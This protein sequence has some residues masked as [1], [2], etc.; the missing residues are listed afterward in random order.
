M[1]TL[2][3]HSERLDHTNVEKWKKSKRFKENKY[4]TPITKNGKII[5]KNAIRTLFDSGYN[6]IDYIYCS[7]LTRTIQTC[8]ILKNEIKKK[9][10][11][12]IKIRIEYGLVEYNSDFPIILKNNKFI[13]DKKKKKKYLDSKLSFKSILKK[14]GNHIDED[15]KSI[16]KFEDVD[17]DTSEL[18]FINRCIKIFNNIHKKIK[19]NDNVLICCHGGIIFGVY[20]YLKKHLNMKNYNSVSSEYCSILVT[21]YNKKK[22]EL[23]NKFNQYK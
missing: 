20:S 18:N 1:I 6:N 3:R 23:I 11:K 21:D 8:L 14:Y 5:A 13:R 10:K 4:D 15:Y 2:I 19:K 9:L 17:F 22:I 12:D 7:P 16:V